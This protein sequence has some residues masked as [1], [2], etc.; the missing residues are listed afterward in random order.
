MDALIEVSSAE[1]NED[2]FKRVKSLLKNIGKGEI[3]IK[4]NNT[5]SSILRQETQEQARERIE[6]AI[7]DKDAGNFISYTAEEFL[8]FSKDLAEAR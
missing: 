7:N 2:L 1:F 3:T 8:K 6:N 5:S 4:V